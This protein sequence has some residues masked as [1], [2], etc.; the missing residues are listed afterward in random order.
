MLYPKLSKFYKNIFIGG[1]EPSDKNYNYFSKKPFK[2]NIGDNLNVCQE[3][4]LNTEMNEK[5]DFITSIYTFTAFVFEDLTKSVKKIY[6]S[7]NNGGE[8]ILVV[9]NEDY[10]KEKLKTK[11]DLFIEKN[12]LKF[13]D[14]TYEE[15]LHY[16]DIPEIGKIIDYNREEKFYIDLFEKNNFKLISNK[17]LDDSGFICTILVFEKN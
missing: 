8:F 5:F 14:R 12:T 6:S 9:A 17:K 7:L 13:K 15:I 3:T 1:C 2:L 11:K 16:S 10:L 4:F